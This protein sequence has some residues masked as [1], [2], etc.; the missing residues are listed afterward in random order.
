MRTNWCW[1]PWHPTRLGHKHGVN[2]G[3]YTPAPWL[4]S[5]YGK[6]YMFNGKIMENQLWMAILNSY[7]KALEGNYLERPH[8]SNLYFIY[9]AALPRGDN[10]DRWWWF[11]VALELPFH[12]GWYLLLPIV[13]LP[14]AYT[15]GRFGWPVVKVD[16]FFTCRSFA[17]D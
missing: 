13:C 9:Q 14:K 17:H 12:K 4:A 1:Q 7:V 2:V 15:W 5:G 3:K 6:I 11:G 10:F 16:A 8:D